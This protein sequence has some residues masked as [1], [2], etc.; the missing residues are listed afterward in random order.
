[1]AGD[2]LSEDG[3]MSKIKNSIGNY[4]AWFPLALSHEKDTLKWC[5][6]GKG[7]FS[8]NT[9]YSHLCSSVPRNPHAKLWKVKVPLKIKIFMW[10]IENES[11]LTRDNLSPERMAGG[12]KVYFLP[13]GSNHKSSIFWLLYGQ[14]R[15]KPGSLCG[16]RRLQALLLC[17]ILDLG[18]TVPSFGRE[19]SVCGPRSNLLGVVA[20]KKW[21]LLW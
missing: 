10:L 5:W 15:L 21:H 12:Q 7:L 4:G 16:G 8:V 18:E 17:P 3:L 13:R 14:I 2:F 6:D 11:I 19:V 20:N 9:M 1:M